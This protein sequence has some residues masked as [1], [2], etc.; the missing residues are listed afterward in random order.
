MSEY[1]TSL[2]L[3]RRDLRLADNTA[4]NAALRFSAQ[5]IAGFV[6]DERQIQP[7]PY[8]SQPALQ[9]MRESL[10]EL[11]VQCKAIGA[12][13]SLF[14]GLP[15][16]VIEDL[17]KQHAI[18][19]VFFNRDYSPFSRQRD[20]EIGTVCQQ[21]GITLHILP[22]ALLTE[23][24]QAV[25][26]DGS[27]YKVFT[28]FY[29]NAKQLPVVLPEALVAGRFL[30]VQTNATLETLGGAEKAVVP[31][32]RTAGLAR[33]AQL[34][35]C[36]DYAVQR[37]FP[38]LS[39]TSQLSAHLKFGTVSVRE[40]YHAIKR[41]LGEGH[42]LLRQL[43]WR[44][45][46]T[47]I[48]YHFPKVFGHAFID[49]FDTLVWDNDHGKF[50]AWA[51]G[52]TGFPIVD[53]GMREL[54]ATGFMHNRVRMITA[55]FL[56]KDLRIS[57]RWGERYFAQHLV[58]YDPCVNNGNW[59]WAASTGC[60]AQPYFRIFNPWLQQQKF[61]PQGDYLYQW[62]PELRKVPIKTIH[63]W[64]QKHYGDFYPAPIVKHSEAVAVTKARYKAAE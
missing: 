7:H 54:N 45:F 60:D 1:Q 9:F 38:A 59:Q 48:A 23:P 57:W 55:S 64:E 29:N 3:F 40:A 19:A 10:A 61:D 28:A 11:A 42:P 21:L 27:A 34:A 26:H 43:Y 46:L 37:D 5:V 49:K 36:T 13:L 32:G 2:F 41:Q 39:A 53:A 30:T 6:L 56:V 62:L 63:Q 44:D 51:D 20:Y 12:E 47:H 15:S 4:L 22:D 50:Q 14:Q 52:K 35:N 16:Q 24:E 25:K 31:G 33:L 18:Q 17:H 8:Q 58:D